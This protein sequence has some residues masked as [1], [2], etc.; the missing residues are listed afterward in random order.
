MSA[1]RRYS[2][3]MAQNPHG[4]TAAQTRR[5]RHK[6]KVATLAEALK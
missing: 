4:L 2:N 3:Y 5:L 1:R 6:A